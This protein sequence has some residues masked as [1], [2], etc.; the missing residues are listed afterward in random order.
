[1]KKLI[2]KLIEHPYIAFLMLINDVKD[3][4]E[5]IINLIKF[6]MNLTPTKPNIDFVRI[7]FDFVI[8]FVLYFV[9]RYIKDFK[10][11]I[12]FYEKQVQEHKEAIDYIKEIEA[13]RATQMY[14]LYQ[15]R[16]I[17]EGDFPN[18]KDVITNSSRERKKERIHFRKN[19]TARHRN[20]KTVDE[21]DKLINAYCLWESNENL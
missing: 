11:A 16:K 12:V 9:L 3:L 7:V 17:V 14:Y 2:S 1:M 8:V 13:Y 19:W 20:T 15:D 21:I 4:V 10:R 6:T 5:W 18:I